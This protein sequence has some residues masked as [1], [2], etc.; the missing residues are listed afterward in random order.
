MFYSS[1]HGNGPAACA[2]PPA[3]LSFD[4]AGNL[5][6]V[7]GANGAGESFTQTSSLLRVNTTSGAATTVCTFAATDRVQ[8]GAIINSTVFAH[9]YGNAPP[10]M[11][12]MVLARQ[13]GAC[14]GS[15]VNTHL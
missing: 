10:R 6:A 1:N 9:F 13:A 3:A 15:Y 5:L 8:V 11:E 14:R 7:T 2:M 12:L 4:C